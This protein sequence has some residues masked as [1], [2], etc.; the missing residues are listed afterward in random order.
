MAC[1][2]NGN[3]IEDQF[4]EITDMIGTRNDGQRQCKAVPVKGQ[5]PV[6]KKGTKLTVAMKSGPSIKETLQAE[7]GRAIGAGQEVKMDRSLW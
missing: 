5:K 1:F 7:I 3:R 2:S 6:V 4:V